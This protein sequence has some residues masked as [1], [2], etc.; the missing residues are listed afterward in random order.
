MKIGTF[1]WNPLG[2]LHEDIKNTRFLLALLGLGLLAAVVCGYFYVALS[3]LV[4]VSEVA[5]TMNMIVQAIISLDTA[6]WI[7]YFTKDKTTP[8]VEPEANAHVSM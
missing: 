5:Q 3:G 6:A 2:F 7:F 4:L 1:E 8:T